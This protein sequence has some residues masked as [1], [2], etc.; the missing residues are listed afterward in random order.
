MA[1]SKPVSPA[2]RGLM[3]A[4]AA[5]LAVITMSLPAEI[6]SAHGQDFEGIV[7]QEQAL[8]DY[9]TP[10]QQRASVM[11]AYN[12]A[13]MREAQQASQNAVARQNALQQRAAQ[14][15]TSGQSALENDNYTGAIY[16]F[17]TAL[18]INPNDTVIRG[19][20]AMAQDYQGRVLYAQ[21]DILAAEA[22]FRQA[23]ATSPGNAAYI[24]D[25]AVT[26]ARLQAIAADRAAQLADQ[27]SLRAMQAILKGNTGHQ[28]V[29]P[30]TQA[31]W[32]WGSDVVDLR[33]AT[34]DVV[35]IAVAQGV[36]STIPMNIDGGV[37]DQP[38][39]DPIQAMPPPAN[40]QEA[41]NQ[42]QEL[43]KEITATQHQ[44][45]AMGFAT[46]AATFEQISDMSG[47]ARKELLKN[48]NKQVMGIL[49]DGVA[50][51][52]QKGIL[53]AV[54]GAEPE[55]VENLLEKMK[56]Y[57]MDSPSLEKCISDIATSTDT[58]AALAADA[59]VVV[60]ISEKFIDTREAEDNLAEGTV[61][62]RQ[63]A[64]L[65]LL[66]VMGMDKPVVEIAKASYQVGAAGFTLALLSG[67]ERQLDAQSNQELANLKIV[68]GRMTALVQ[69]R[70][71]LRM[72][73]PQLPH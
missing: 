59:E 23:L 31:Q 11:G 16:D 15:S 27:N 64:T 46:N 42:I 10:E 4:A 34:T 58:R 9:W 17:S 6:P 49:A 25:L 19:K 53:K 21:G 67:S 22:Y 66:S 62:S 18:Q 44:L 39:A 13:R 36:N 54:E 14:L 50:D 45:A 33:G 12:A 24:R 73:L 70:N 43:G 72:L 8:R 29:A 2:A 56:T 41:Q 20:L 63:E 57:G 37:G 51:L 69:K 48:L 47:D 7:E 3:V 5:A 40:Q 60:E 55:T 1:W 71:A 52:G 61:E 28:W 30:P 35:N 26:R 68:S 65:T 38:K 32:P